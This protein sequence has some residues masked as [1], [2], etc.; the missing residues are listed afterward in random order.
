VKPGAIIDRDED[1]IDVSWRR[2]FSPAGAQ[3]ARRDDCTKAGPEMPV[4]TLLRLQLKTPHVDHPGITAEILATDGRWGN[5]VTNVDAE[6]FLKL[7]Y[8]HGQE[9]PGRMGGKEMKSSSGELSAMCRWGS[10]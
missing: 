8:R 4:A 6:E 10:R 3:V 9:V 2:H 1:V 5:L 7:G